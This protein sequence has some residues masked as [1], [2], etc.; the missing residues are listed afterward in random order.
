MKRGIYMLDTI[1]VAKEK[2]VNYFEKQ[3]VK[4]TKKDAIFDVV[5]GVGTA[6]ALSAL[7][8]QGNYGA[9]GIF[10]AVAMAGNLAKGMTLGRVQG[11][12]EGTK[13]KDRTNGKI[14]KFDTIRGLITHEDLEEVFVVQFYTKNGK[15]IMQ[16]A[17]P[18]YTYMNAVIEGSQGLEDIELATKFNIEK[19]YKRKGDN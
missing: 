13:T 2:V 15:P 1:K 8:R 3:E 17:K 10:A 7:A 4:Y 11:R 9:V 18:I 6:I 5:V 12:K 14:P 16:T 19:Y